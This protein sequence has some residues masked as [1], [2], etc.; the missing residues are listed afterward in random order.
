[1]QG[2]WDGP[3][4]HFTAE[5]QA[6]GDPLAALYHFVRLDGTRALL[7]REG[8][9]FSVPLKSKTTATFHG[10][11]LES[12]NAKRRRRKLTE[13]TRNTGVGLKVIPVDFLHF[14]VEFRLPICVFTSIVM[15][16][17]S[18]MSRSMRAP[19]AARR[20]YNA[21]NA[22]GAPR[23]GG[24]QGHYQGQAGRDATRRRRLDYGALFGAHRVAWGLGVS[25]GVC[26]LSVHE[27]R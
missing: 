18:K 2:P 13:S 24:L 26:G 22:D 3:Q 23:P 16:C 10:H 14:R 11:L 21:V 19:G 9:E 20:R 8:L 1:M 4:Q 17:S 7:Q 12:F 6:S 27:L 5:L 15:S 25:R